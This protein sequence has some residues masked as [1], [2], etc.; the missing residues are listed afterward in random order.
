[1]NE[2]IAL[3]LKTVKDFSSTFLTFIN[4]ISEETDFNHKELLM[5]LG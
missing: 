5:I 3:A 4:L 1:M 2:K